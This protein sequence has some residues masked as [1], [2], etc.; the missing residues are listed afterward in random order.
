MTSNDQPSRSEWLAGAFDWLRPTRSTILWGTLL[1]NVELFMLLTYASVASA[2]I[3]TFVLYPLVWLNAAL[4]VFARVRPVQVPVSRRR[5]WLAAT[6]A[7][8]YFLV[9][10]V[11]TGH[12]GAGVAFVETSV[13]TGLRVVLDRPPGLSPAVHYI[14][15]YVS[16]Q[17][18]PF[19]VAG[20]GA[21]AYLVY[22][23]VLDLSRVALGGVIG[24]FSCL[25]CTFPVLLGVLTGAAG[26]SGSGLVAATASLGLGT[27]TVVFLVTVLLLS[28]RPIVE[29]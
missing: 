7:S 14:G 12:V 28:W 26:L 13:Y 18:I 20:Y 10:M 11:L 8:G 1:L 27:S 3:T 2:R 15:E 17:L 4:W 23:L 9:L 6:V 24:L 22:V 5:R 25:S 19:Y 16:V 29:Q 21:L